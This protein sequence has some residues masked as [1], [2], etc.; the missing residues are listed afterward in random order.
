MSTAFE[1]FSAKV[2]ETFEA[3]DDANE[4]IY[5]AWGNLANLTVSEEVYGVDW[6][7]YAMLPKKGSNGAMAK[8]M[9]AHLKTVDPEG[10]KAAKANAKTIRDFIKGKCEARNQAASFRMTFS[11][12][13]GYCV[14]E[15]GISDKYVS[16]EAKAEGSGSSKPHA[17]FVGDAIRMLKNH[18]EEAEGCYE[19]K[20][21]WPSI[22]EAAEND[23]ILKT[24]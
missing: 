12:F 16:D 11:R 9:T 18:L 20:D 23:G 8:R 3:I 2:N 10:A 6:I 5:G 24:D 19:L 13:L 7:H 21:L 22:E 4:K 14:A 15:A 1:I 17:T